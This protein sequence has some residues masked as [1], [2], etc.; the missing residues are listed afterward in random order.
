MAAQIT[1]VL[2]DAGAPRGGPISGSHRGGGS[3]L[4]C[5]GAA[6]R[7]AVFN[8]EPQSAQ[9]RTESTRIVSEGAVDR[10][11]HSVAPAHDAVLQ[12][13]HVCLSSGPIDLRTLVV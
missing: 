6:S 7:G 5:G 1:D 13:D 3:P 8:T 11:S 10:R 9:R 12:P 4:L 2:V